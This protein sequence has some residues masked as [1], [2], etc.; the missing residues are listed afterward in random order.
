MVFLMWVDLGI[1]Y[2][3]GEAWLV[4][5]IY[6]I[7]KHFFYKCLFYHYRKKKKPST[8]IFILEKESWGQESRLNKVQ[9]LGTW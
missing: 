7:Q 2:G 5:N 6:I 3:T 8:D 9:M 1:C 4:E